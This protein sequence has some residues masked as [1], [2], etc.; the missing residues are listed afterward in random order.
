[1]YRTRFHS[2]PIVAAFA[3]IFV[4]SILIA[5]VTFQRTYGGASWDEGHS[6]QQTSDGGYI[7]C[8][9]TESYGSGNAD[10]WL[11]KTDARGDT[12][13]TRT[14][15]GVNW[16]E[17]Y[18]VEQTTD[19]GYIIAGYT[20]SP[21][22]GSDDVYLVKA[23]SSG[24]TV[25]TRTY[26]GTGNDDGWSVQQTSDGGYVI[27]G[28]TWSFG[29]GASDVYLIRTDAHGDTLWTTTFG[30]AWDEGGYSL[31][32]TA[33]GGYIITGYAHSFGAGYWDV[34]LVRT[35]TNGG[36][37]WTR[38]YGGTDNDVGTSAQPTT[39]GGYIIAGHAQSFGAGYWDIYLIKTDA[40]GDTLWTRTFG[41]ASGDCANSVQ[42]TADGGYIIAGHTQSFG[43]GNWDVWL[44]KTD[45]YGDTLWTRTLGDT[46]DDGGRSVRQT[47][48]GGYIATGWTGSFV[49]DDYDVY[50]IKLDSLGNVGVAEEYPKPQA[51]GRK[52]A[53][54]VARSLPQGT[55]AFD[56]M[57]RRV[58]HLKPGIYFLRTAVTAASRKV[59]LVE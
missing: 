11:V 13:W 34:Y 26:G 43:A 21:G 23:D 31:R 47:A 10:V 4:P 16:E 12:L 32:Q 17:G 18:S 2:A 51:I 35:D 50:L 15:G 45:A 38:T 5:Q 54:T 46:S 39:D 56:A 1:M 41:G 8:G 6:V 44:I 53:A 36:T 25:W 9:S 42:Q 14:Y 28:C 49:A 3:A 40:S 27:A 20:N 24:D 22:A 7:V 19:G 30:G 59:L 58:L 33:D 55:V 57:G 52:L 29:A 37:L 48:D